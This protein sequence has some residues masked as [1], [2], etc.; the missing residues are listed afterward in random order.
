[1]ILE[2]SKRE[3]VRYISDHRN[4]VKSAFN[5]M[6]INCEDILRR[7]QIPI[8]KL[9]ILVEEHDISKYGKEEFEPYRQRFYPCDGE[10][11]DEKA[12]EEAWKHHYTNNKHH[13]NYWVD[14]SEDMPPIYVA[15]MTL[16]WIAMSMYKGGDAIE[17]YEQNKKKIK[18]S[19]ESEDL[20]YELAE[21]YYN[22]SM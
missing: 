21:R 4:N 9:R 11:Y 5:Q 15:E 7:Y 18:I 16:D 10:V 19:K 13:W 14:M 3:Y 8:Y 20:F 12:F 6:K 2:E 1:M 22:I 17:W